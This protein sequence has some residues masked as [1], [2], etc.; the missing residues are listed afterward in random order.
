MFDENSWEDEKVIKIEVSPILLPKLRSLG[1]FFIALIEFDVFY[2]PMVA[3]AVVKEGSKFI[4]HVTNESN[5]SE[6]YAGVARTNLSKLETVDSFGE[7]ITLARI[8]KDEDAEIVNVLLISS[9]A[10]VKEADM[11]LLADAIMNS[12]NGERE[13]LQ[14]G[15]KIG[16]NIFFENKQSKFSSSLVS[17]KITINTKDRPLKNLNLNTI[18]GFIVLD[19]NS[20]MAD[21]S[22]LP[23]WI[24]AQ[25]LEPIELLEIIEKQLISFKEG[26]I[27]TIFIKS[28]AFIAMRIPH[29]MKY[30]FLT[31]KDAGLQ[32]AHKIG[33]WLKPISMVIAE[34][35]KMASKEEMFALLAYLDQASTRNPP[36]FKIRSIAQLLIRS[37]RIK[38]TT[39]F[40]SIGEFNIIAPSF[41]GGKMWKDLRELEGNICIHALAERWGRDIIDVVN[42]LDWAQGRNLIFL[43]E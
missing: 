31:F 20:K 9:N 34:E 1:I 36:E 33:I 14:M 40:N 5:I 7:K 19:L 4:Q 23:A 32:V 41:I 37:K 25:K 12:A 39:H 16:T 15:I 43:L 22:N 8:E 2:G 27:A 6:I 3:I 35:W 18:A 13:N 28:L 24:K 11:S 21:F 10:E 30:I 38:P 26:E 17:T 42:I 29:S